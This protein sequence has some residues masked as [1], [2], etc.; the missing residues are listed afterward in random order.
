MKYSINEQQKKELTDLKSRAL[1]VN[2]KNGFPRLPKEQNS[3]STFDNL[4]IGFE[5]RLDNWRKGLIQLENPG[6]T[7]NG[8]KRGETSD[9]SVKTIDLRQFVMHSF[10]ELEELS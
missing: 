8:K 7:L 6:G 3:Q 2:Y 1:S 4:M 5:K 9:S 10:E